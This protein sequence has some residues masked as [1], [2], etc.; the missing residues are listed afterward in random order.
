[1]AHKKVTI[2]ITCENDTIGSMQ[3]LVQ[4]LNIQRDLVFVEY[5]DSELTNDDTSYDEIRLA[6]NT[7]AELQI[8]DVT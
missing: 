3:N 7:T 2:T 8:E 1:M 5:G 6:D 4:T